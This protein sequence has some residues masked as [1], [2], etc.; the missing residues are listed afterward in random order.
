MHPISF[1]QLARRAPSGDSRD[2]CLL[3]P[4]QPTPAI[5]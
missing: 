2:A 4:T 1:P 3:I 5:L